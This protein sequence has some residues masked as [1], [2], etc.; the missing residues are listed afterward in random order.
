MIFTSS[1]VLLTHQATAEK[2]VIIFTQSV[3]TSVRLS[4]NQIRATTDTMHEN[5]DH[6][7]AG[8]WWVTLKS[9]D[10]YYFGSPSFSRL[11]F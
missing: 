5:N 4:Q 8:A 9:P 6:L 10:L 7:L 1:K 3:R 2:V 11:E